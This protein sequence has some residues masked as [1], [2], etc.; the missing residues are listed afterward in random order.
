MDQVTQPT[1]IAS[2]GDRPL[3]WRIGA[4][5]EQAP[6][7]NLNAIRPSS[8]R[9]YTIR[10]SAVNVGRYVQGFSANRAVRPLQWAK[11]DQAVF[12]NWKS[13]N[14]KEWETADAA[15]GWKKSEE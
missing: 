2:V 13:G 5:A 15:I 4:L 6:R 11:R 10:L 9:L 14:S 12:T 1:V 7:L 8:I 3:E